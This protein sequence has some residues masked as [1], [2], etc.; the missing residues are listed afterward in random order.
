MRS[1]GFAVTTPIFFN[2]FKSIIVKLSKKLP[3]GVEFD[4][5]VSK[6]ESKLSPPQKRT[7]SS[8]GKSARASKKF[9][10]NKKEETI[11]FQK[12]TVYTEIK[13]LK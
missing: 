13:T 9:T 6:A 4:L 7:L 1:K 5:R 11:S 2:V 8:K 3:R 12:Y 10:L